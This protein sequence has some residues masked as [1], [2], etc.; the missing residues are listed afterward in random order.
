VLRKSDAA[1]VAA[2][3]EALQRLAMRFVPMK[4]EEQQSQLMVNRAR[5]GFVVERT[6]TS[7]SS[8]CW[9]SLASACRIRPKSCAVKP[10]NTSK[11]ARSA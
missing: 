5:Q 1:D 6:A 11:D 4:S 9:P 7:A 2:I 10:P 3:C 8:G